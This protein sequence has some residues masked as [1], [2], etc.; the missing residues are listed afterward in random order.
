MIRQILVHIFLLKRN[1]N[2]ITHNDY[3]Y[4]EETSKFLEDN[5]S[6]DDS[7][8]PYTLRD[9]SFIRTKNKRSIDST[10]K[11]YASQISCDA[12]CDKYCLFVC[13]KMI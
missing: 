11:E 9:N 1:D 3:E 13:R 7:E 8:T 10:F 6:F 2:K 12:I 5:E 4:K